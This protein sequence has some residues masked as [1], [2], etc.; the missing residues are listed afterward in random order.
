MDTTYEQGYT[1]VDWLIPVLKSA[2][3]EFSGKHYVF[4][5]WLMNQAYLDEV[6]KDS[7]L[8]M[9]SIILLWAYV[10][11]HLQSFFLSTTC[12]LLI[13]MSFPPA[14][15]IFRG[16]LGITYFETLNIV[17]IF[18][19]LGIGADDMFVVNDTWRQSL[20]FYPD[21]RDLRERFI[22]TA[23]RSGKST[24][25][26]STTTSIALFTMLVSPL[27]PIKSFGT[28]GGCVVLTNYLNFIVI[29]PLLIS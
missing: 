28:F 13:F 19:L 22:F 9:M 17:I 12:V 5:E 20:F 24:L 3:K 27:V 18:I 23:C 21:P 2:Q 10:S 4:Q 8:V 29:F 16:I 6:E 14:Y 25:L 7:R 15:A 1:T 26:T 11:F